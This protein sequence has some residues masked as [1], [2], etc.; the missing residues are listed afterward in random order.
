M[1]FRLTFFGDVFFS[2][3]L[4]W[5]S[6]VSLSPKRRS[7]VCLSLGMCSL[8]FLLRGVLSSVSVTVFDE[9][10]FCL[11]FFGGVL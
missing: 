1:F 6:F 9:A 4:E 5:R 11:S 10:F 2:L 8:N 3:S 7:F